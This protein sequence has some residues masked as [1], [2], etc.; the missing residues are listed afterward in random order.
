MSPE[1]IQGKEADHRADIWAV[2]VILYELITGQRPFDGEYEASIL[3]A[4]QNEETE[5]LAR[6]KSGTPDELQRMVNKS[7]AK[8]PEKRY[9]YVDEVLVDL[10]M[11]REQP[12][13]GSSKIPS[14]GKTKKKKTFVYAGT[15]VI[16]MVAVLSG[17]YLFNETETEVIDSI[18][19]LSFDNLTEN[20][21]LDYLSDGIAQGISNRISQLPALRK[22]I[23]SPY[24]KKY[25]GGN[26]DVK[27]VADECDVKGV[28]LGTMALL[29]NQI[30]INI[31][32]V[33]G[34]DSRIIWGNKYTRP[35]TQ[36]HVM[37]ENLT[38]LIVH[39]LGIQLTPADEIRLGEDQS[40][41]PE[42]YAAYKR[43]RFH[44]NKFTEKGIRTSIDYFKEA[45]TFDPDHALSY[46][47]MANAYN[48]LGFGQ[49]K[50]TTS[51]KEAFSM[52]KRAALKAIEIDDSLSEA[53]AVL[54][55]IYLVYDFDLELAESELKHA[56]R[57]DPNSGR[58]HAHYSLY[59][60][61]LGRQEEAIDELKLAQQ[62]SPLEPILPAN[63]G[64]YFLRLGDYDNAVIQCKKALEL[65]PN[66]PAAYWCLADI[67]GRKGMHDQAVKEARK[68]VEFSD[69]NP[70]FVGS[71]GYYLAKAGCMDE[72]KR[73]L[74][75][76]LERS[77]KTYVSSRAI[78]NIYEA[79]G[80]KTRTLD[81]LE[82]AYEERAA[83]IV[84]LK[85][86]SDFYRNVNTE[87]RFKALLKKMNLEP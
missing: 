59:L 3:Y 57:L 85:V 56:I 62:L 71:L 54:G 42:A 12:D 69:R 87:P 1:Q 35:Q 47:Y 52:A 6:Y 51:P 18:A 19:V 73:I 58:G 44:L 31:Q 40:V 86:E 14:S 16:I 2:G 79:L 81:Y 10:K 53:H 76:L 60:S 45:L 77:S 4:I 65:D 33:D 68:A 63:T 29:D 22:V 55:I 39:N 26:L 74:R 49:G 34:R 37:E 72:A 75:E 30:T 67:Y 84:N 21:E 83:W 28:V 50:G 20:P 41:V 5:P 15:A 13:M 7:L 8:S 43:G 66:F 9:Q 32:L 17:F 80:D 64:T 36:V 78:A 27:I 48:T 70:F 23:A 61:V 24:L 46:A 82:K 11:A 38:R 25:K